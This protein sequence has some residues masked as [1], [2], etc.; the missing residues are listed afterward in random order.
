MLKVKREI[1]SEK[2]K[3][4]KKKE[5]GGGPFFLFSYYIYVKERLFKYNRR[6]FRRR[7]K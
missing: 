3:K 6:R 1:K 2:T 5:K 7:K 4:E